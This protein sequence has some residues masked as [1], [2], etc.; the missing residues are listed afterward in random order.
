MDIRLQ[1]A[2][3]ADTTIIYKLAEEIWYK[4]YVEIIGLEQVKYMLGGIYS[5]ESLKDQM[6]NKGHKFY[7]VYENNQRIGFVSISSTDAKNYWLQKFYLLNNNQNK[8][9]GTI[10]FGLVINEMNQPETLRLTVN[11]QNYKSINFYFKNGFKIEQVADFDIG[12]GYF[13]NDFVMLKKM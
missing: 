12:N 8:G 6:L 4:H 9:I 7:L 11:R 5:D 10:V 13:M 1:Q 3:E 2:T